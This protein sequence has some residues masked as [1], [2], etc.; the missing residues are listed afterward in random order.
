MKEKISFGH[1]KILRGHQE[2]DVELGTLEFSSIWGRQREW[3]RWTQLV[4]AFRC[5]WEQPLP[6]AAEGVLCA[7][8]WRSSSGCKWGPSAGPNLSCPGGWV[9]RSAR[10]VHAKY[11]HAST[12]SYV[13]TTAASLPVGGTCPPPPRGGQVLDHSARSLSAILA[14]CGSLSAK[15]M[16]HEVCK[17][18]YACKKILFPV[19]IILKIIWNIFIVDIIV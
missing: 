5:W 12:V 2:R 13:D 3:K 11:H 8:A 4:L 10:Y 17:G 7:G 1:L 15:A 9:A 16:L 18:M 19:G 14:A 6:G